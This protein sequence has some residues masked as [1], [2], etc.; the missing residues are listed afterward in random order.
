MGIN[1]IEEENVFKTSDGSNNITMENWACGPV[2][3]C[4]P[5]DDTALK[6]EDC[7]IAFLFPMGDYNGEWFDVDCAYEDNLICEFLD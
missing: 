1:D 7:V 2:G 4:E 5:N 3:N 6:D